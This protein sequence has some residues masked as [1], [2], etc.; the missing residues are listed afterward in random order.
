VNVKE[1]DSVQKLLLTSFLLP[2]SS[3]FAGAAVARA[4]RWLHLH[5]LLMSGGH[6]MMYQVCSSS[7]SFCVLCTK[8]SAK[9]VCVYGVAC[10]HKYM[11][12]ISHM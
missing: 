9:Y 8:C 11:F 12:T 1:T 10:T 2:I 5:A 7:A 4:L 3:N 6:C